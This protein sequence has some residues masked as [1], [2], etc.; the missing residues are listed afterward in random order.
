[1]NKSFSSLLILS[2]LI[3]LSIVSIARA[4]CQ[5]CPA[6]YSSINSQNVSC[7]ANDECDPGSCP[8]T[9]SISS[10]FRCSPGYVNG[11][12]RDSPCVKCGQ[13]QI[14]NEARTVCDV[15]DPG[16]S[17]DRQG[18]QCNPCPP[19]QFSDKA[20]SLCQDCKPGEYSDLPQTI[21]CKKCRKGS[22]N[23][24]SRSSYCVPCGVGNY[25]TEVGAV[26]TRT[27]SQ[28]SE[29]FYCPNQMSDSEIP[30][31]R[32]TSCGVGSSAPSPCRLMT[33]APERSNSCHATSQLYIFILAGIGAFVAIVSI[34]FYVK[35]RNTREPV[36]LPSTDK[37]RL[38]PP[39]T[40]GP[41][42][43]GL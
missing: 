19:G 33:D 26:S 15:C 9:N 8:L 13:G 38:I 41:V 22:Y 20:G 18:I 37:D 35:A 12:G 27:C 31:P 2:I 29:G 42:Y 34:I 5:V 10:C 6:G 21:M 30:C 28:C 1:M 3:S 32:G 17:S 14:S 40:E 43:S 4:D 11:A 23:P 36:D 25:G 16:T 7:D 39:P 24:F